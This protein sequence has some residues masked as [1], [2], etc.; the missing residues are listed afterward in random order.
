V[1]RGER[2][3]GLSLKHVGLVEQHLVL[4]DEL[5]HGFLNTQTLRGGH[6]AYVYTCHVPHALMQPVG[7]IAIVG[8]SSPD[9]AR[10][11]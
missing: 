4:G 11:P 2:S 5:Q 9:T 6:G 1:A 7:N 10:S 3:P 8:P